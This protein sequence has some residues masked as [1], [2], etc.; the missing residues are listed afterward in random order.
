MEKS[1][2]ILKKIVQLRFVPDAL[3]VNSM[4]SVTQASKRRLIFAAEIGV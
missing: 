4:D 1:C 2:A 3:T